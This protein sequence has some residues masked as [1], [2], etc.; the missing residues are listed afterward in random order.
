MGAVTQ[1]L[2]ASEPGQRHYFSLVTGPSRTAD[3]EAPSP[4]VSRDRAQCVIM[5]G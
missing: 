4:S 2:T 3:I 5:L 1:Q